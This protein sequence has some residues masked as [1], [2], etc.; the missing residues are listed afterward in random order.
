[1]YPHAEPPSTPPNVFGGD[2]LKLMIVTLTLT[3]RKEKEVTLWMGVL[4]IRNQHPEVRESA[5]R[6]VMFKK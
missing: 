5:V 6:E 2:F 4:D 3:T 1:L